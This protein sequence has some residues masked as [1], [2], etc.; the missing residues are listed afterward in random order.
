MIDG[1]VKIYVSTDLLQAKLVEDML[2]QNGIESHIVSR[3]DSVLP[4]LGEAALYTPE[5]RAEEALAVLHGSQL[6][7]DE[8]E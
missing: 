4:M 3:P 8:E 5:H 6:A 1:W 7:M 2:K